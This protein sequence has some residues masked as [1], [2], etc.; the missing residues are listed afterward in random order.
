MTCQCEASQGALCR[1]VREADPP[2]VK[3]ASEG[4]PAREHV[5]D[6]LGDLGMAREFGALG[7]HP[8]FERGDQDDAPF[9][10]LAIR[11]S[12]E[13]PLISRSMS[14]SASMRLTASNAIGEIGVT[15]LPRRAFAAMSASS[16]NL[17]RAW[18]Q[19]SAPTIGPGFRS[20]R[21]RRL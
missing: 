4:R 19:H 15:L 10:A 2:I 20:A 16:K 6:R 3:E 5:V 18:L 12:P 7:A 1:V 9:L 13:R 14:N 8:V 11:I 21:Y 17:R